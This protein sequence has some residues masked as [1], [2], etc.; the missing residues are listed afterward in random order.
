MPAQNPFEN[1]Y[2]FKNSCKIKVDDDD[3]K[4]FE[5]YKNL[6]NQFEQVSINENQDINKKSIKSI[7]HRACAMYTNKE[8]S[9]TGVTQFIKKPESLDKKTKGSAKSPELKK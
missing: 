8:I 1:Q 5:D 7:L 9:L 3:F 4:Y 2:E 6:Y